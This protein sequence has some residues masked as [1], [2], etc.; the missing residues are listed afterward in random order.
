MT[1]SETVAD[2]VSI[3][4]AAEVTGLSV[5]TIRYYEDIGL[6]P[7]APRRNSGARTGGNRL[8]DGAAIG[9]LKFAH[10][11]RSLG[12]SLE[13]IR[14]L[15]AIAEQGC[16]SERPEYGDILKQHLAGIDEHIA[17]LGALRGQ[18]KQLLSRKRSVVPRAC[19]WESCDCLDAEGAT[20]RGHAK[21]RSQ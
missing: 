8:Y 1:R 10:S 15:V 3:G 7:K 17:R 16:P 21:A 4:D 19:C 11:A 2:A 5:K 18:I 6:V 12:L 9:R 14:L 13:E 20:K